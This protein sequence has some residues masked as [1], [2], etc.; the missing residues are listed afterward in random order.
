MATKSLPGVTILVG[1]DGY[2]RVGIP[3]HATPS[4]AVLWYQSALH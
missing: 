4:D 3:T 1:L 2:R